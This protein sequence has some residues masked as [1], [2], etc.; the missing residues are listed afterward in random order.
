MFF[1]VSVFFVLA[2]TTRSD[3]DDRPVCVCVLPP[4]AP[5]FPRTWSHDAPARCSLPPAAHPQ[6]PL[7]VCVFCVRVRVRV[8]VCVTFAHRECH[9]TLKALT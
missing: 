9:R 3:Y 4:A 5:A 1:F 6:I 8:C 2:R 7:P